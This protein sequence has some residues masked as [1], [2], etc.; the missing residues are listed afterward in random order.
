MQGCRASGR[1]RNASDRQML[2][3]SLFI[4]TEWDWENLKDFQR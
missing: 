4:V 2:T 3:E 1:E